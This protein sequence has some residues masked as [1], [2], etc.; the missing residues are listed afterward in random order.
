MLVVSEL[1]GWFRFADLAAAGRFGKRFEWRESQMNT[2][3]STHCF[4]A[5]SRVFAGGVNSPVRAFK[6]VGGQPLFIA[7]AL[8]AKLIDVDGNE[9]VD[10]VGSFGP[11]ILG[12]SHPEVIS[13]VKEALA[14][15]FSFGAP[16]ER[17][18]QLA[19]KIQE[20]FPS[21]EKM[22]FV[23]SGTEACLSAIRLAR[24]FTGRDKII[25]FTGC[26]HG[27]GDML[28]VKA[29]SGVLTLGLPDSPGVPKGAT[30]DTI[31]LPFNDL[32]LVEKTLTELPKDIAA[33]ILEPF[34]GNAGMIRPQD[35]FLEGLRSLTARFGSLL[36]FDEVMTGFRIHK[37]GA[38]GLT[39]IKPDLTT[40]GKVIGGGMPIGAFGG[41][42]DILDHLAPAGPVYQAGTLSGNPVAMAC[43]LKTLEVLTREPAFQQLTALTR[44]FI[45]EFSELARKLKIPFISDCEGGMF[46]FYFQDGPV[47][48]YEEALQSD[49]KRFAK[50][51]R[52]MLEEGVYLAP[53][54]F[55]AGFVSCAHTQ[56]DIE[57][58]LKAADRVLAK[59]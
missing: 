30:Q 35:G 4:E 20:F 11:A 18:T 39:G 17:E 37:G 45:N 6:S 16:C 55:E 32:N 2:E 19:L 59:L 56:Q 21:L 26:Y 47:T 8:G 33:V 29:G 7:K 28:L 13:A 22:R 40:L 25:K 51:H 38:Q 48:C 42:R 12:H 52:R 31:V 46:G 14:E 58:T 57:H 36:I 24:G 5:A 34:V 49:V 27:H 43:G 53:S 41:R 1:L 50:F 3:K 54:A 15:G 10:Y 9:Y 23:S 44:N